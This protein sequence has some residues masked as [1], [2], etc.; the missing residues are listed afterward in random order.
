MD[1]RGA[2]RRRLRAASRFSSC[3]SVP[4]I[5]RRGLRYVDALEAYCT[6]REDDILS[7]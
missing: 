3:W 4:R 5:A 2:A 7:W 1:R 6:E